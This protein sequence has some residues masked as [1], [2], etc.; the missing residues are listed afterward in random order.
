MSS[1][2]REI[3]LAVL[4]SVTVL[5]LP[6]IASSK[7]KRH[8]GIPSCSSIARKEIAS[9]AQAGRLKLVK[10][11]GNFCAF[12]GEHH[13]HY[14]PTLDLEV[15][16]YVKS[17]WD[18]AKSDA[19]AS[20]TKNGSRFGRGNSKLLFVSGTTTSAGLGPCTRHNDRPGKGEAKL[21]PACAGRAGS[22]APQRPRPRLRQSATISI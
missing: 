19:Q 12:T 14:E 17:I 15:V 5:V 16:P 6:A 3:T 18:R 7:P 4:V 22:V 2:R 10:K 21:G 20:A 9:L 8:S 1:R 11:I 13:G